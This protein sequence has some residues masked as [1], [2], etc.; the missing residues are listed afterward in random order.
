M[1]REKFQTLTEQMFYILLCL[2]EECCGIEVMGKVKA[3]SQGRVIVGAGT[4]YHLLE[5]FVLADMIVETKVEGRKR[6]YLITSYGRQVLAN[7]VQR[8][9]ILLNDYQS[10]R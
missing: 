6:S 9:Q 8:L 5:N 1:A 7:E 2:Q 4:L 10:T 3:L